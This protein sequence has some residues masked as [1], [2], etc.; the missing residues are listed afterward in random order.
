MAAA[1]TVY[2]KD[3]KTGSA[4]AAGGTA[5]FDFPVPTDRAIRIRVS[6]SM[7]A[8]TGG[9]AH[10]TV[11]SSLVAEYVVRNNNGT[12]VAPGAMVGSANPMNSGGSLASRVEVDEFAGAAPSTANWTISGTNVRLTVTNNHL[13][14][15]ADIT[16]SAEWE[17]TG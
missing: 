14:Q 10:L 16:V 2:G 8:Q 7:T 13:T 1:N 15:A 6:V 11:L 5:T 9:P 12:L 4:A 3:R 17:L